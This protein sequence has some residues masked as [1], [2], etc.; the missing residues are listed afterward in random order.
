[1]ERK[2]HA[3][4][5]SGVANSRITKWRQS[6]NYF[7]TSKFLF[8][9]L[10]AMLLFNS[11][12]VTNYYQVFKMQSK[13]KLQN[14][15]ETLIYSDANISI[16]YNFWSNGGNIDFAI[17]NNSD[18]NIYLHKKECF[19]IC[20][21]YAYDY[22]KNLT[23]SSTKGLQVGETVVKNKAASVAV[24]GINVY[25]YD[26]TNFIAAAKSYGISAFNSVSSSVSWE[27]AE[28]ICIPPKATKVISEFEKITNTL[29]RSCDLFRYPTNK[30]TNS[31]KF[32]EDESPLIFSNKL[33]YSIDDSKELI[34]ISNDFYVSEI[35]N[36]TEK[37]MIETKMEREEYCGDKSTKSYQKRYWKDATP[38]KFY[39]RYTKSI[40]G[41]TF[42]H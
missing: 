40:N 11:C 19:F 28:I 27:E 9:S 31:I 24:S 32:L 34:S 15:G 4:L 21:G 20:N 6:K 26:Q 7:M 2:N 5:K 42:K 1:M 29:I 13:E 12:S 25:N 37:N 33:S 10:T 22:F 39:I 18:K 14:D 35:T 23:Y 38:D 36:L 17:T 16:S 41:T 3:M 8:F 30:Q